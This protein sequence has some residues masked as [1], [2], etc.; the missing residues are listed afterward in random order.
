MSARRAETEAPLRSPVG[1]KIGEKLPQ[2]VV[3]K[4]RSAFSE[5]KHV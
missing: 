3:F 2:R 5:A 4:L 1:P